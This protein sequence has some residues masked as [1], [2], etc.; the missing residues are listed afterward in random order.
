M[1]KLSLFTLVLSPALGTSMALAKATCTITPVTDNRGDN[2]K[3]EASATGSMQIQLDAKE[4]RVVAMPVLAYE[5]EYPNAD[6]IKEPKLF[7]LAFKSISELVKTDASRVQ[8]QNFNYVVEIERKNNRYVV[9]HGQSN[10]YE[11]NALEIPFGGMTKT[12]SI[13][14]SEYL[15]WDGA[16]EGHTLQVRLECSED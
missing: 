13:Q 8:G 3:L 12:T 5:T 11:K 14:E 16:K 2:V 7:K 1:K 6:P 9:R 10:I 4:K 15:Y